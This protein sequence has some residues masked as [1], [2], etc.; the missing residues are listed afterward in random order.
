MA[1]SP[2]LT[3]SHPVLVCTLRSS[4]ILRRGGGGASGHICRRIVLLL[5]QVLR[6]YLVHSNYSVCTCCGLTFLLVLKR[7]HLPFKLGQLVAVHLDCAAQMER[8]QHERT[9]SCC[10]FFHVVSIPFTLPGQDEKMK[11]KQNL[12]FV[13]VSMHTYFIIV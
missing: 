4:G 9:A 1:E 8:R 11:P 13:M 5:L 2:A 6:K 12:C 10:P 3:Y 7:L